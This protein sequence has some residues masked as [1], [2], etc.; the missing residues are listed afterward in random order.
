V[1]QTEG[2]RE[3]RPIFAE[4]GEK[5]SPALQKSGSA[6]P[7]GPEASTPMAR[8]RR[9]V[10]RRKGRTGRL[11][12]RNATSIASVMPST[13]NAVMASLA[14]VMSTGRPE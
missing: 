8:A 2:K 13:G 1:I 6:M 3:R 14:V 4:R 12:R 5:I 7:I 9:E 10:T 11:N